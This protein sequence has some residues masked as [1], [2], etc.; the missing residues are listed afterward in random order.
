MPNAD[1]LRQKIDAMP[2]SVNK[3]TLADKIEI[4]CRWVESTD[5]SALGNFA[6]DDELMAGVYAMFWDNWLRPPVY[7]KRHPAEIDPFSIS[8]VLPN[9]LRHIFREPEGEPDFWN[10]GYHL[11]NEESLFPYYTEVLFWLNKEN[12]KHYYNGHTARLREKFQGDERVLSAF[13][14][15]EYLVDNPSSLPYAEVGIWNHDA[16]KKFAK[17]GID[18]DMAIVLLDSERGYADA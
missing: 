17:D 5:R 1:S 10:F 16:I 15:M 13:R 6:L 11:F 2:H 3:Q 7:H 4:A 8:S 14:R 9:A 12:T 18:A